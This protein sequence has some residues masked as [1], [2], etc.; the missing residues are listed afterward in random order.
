MTIAAIT[1]LYAPTTPTQ[2]DIYTIT[3]AGGSDR[4][5]YNP[6]TSSLTGT[7]GSTLRYN[8]QVKIWFFNY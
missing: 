3:R 5:V 8:L 2:T 6:A 7:T 1:P 4:I